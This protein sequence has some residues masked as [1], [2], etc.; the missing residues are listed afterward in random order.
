MKLYIGPFLFEDETDPEE[1]PVASGG[2]NNGN[3][4][5]NQNCWGCDSYAGEVVGN[6]ACCV[7]PATGGYELC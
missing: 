1:P 3:A 5:N 7:T 2:P 6:D 4:G